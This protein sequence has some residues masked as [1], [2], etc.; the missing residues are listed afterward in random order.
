MIQLV[1]LWWAEAGR[2]GVMPLD[3]RF[4]ERS[5]P[6]VA[7]LDPHEVHLLPRCGAHP[8]ARG[9]RHAEP[10]VGGGGGGRD[11]EGRRRRA[12]RGD[13]WRHQRLV[14]LSQGGRADV[15]LQPRLDRADVHPRAEAGRARPARG[16]LRLR[17]GRQGGVRRGRHR[18]HL[19]RRQ[20]VAEGAI[21]RTAAFGYSL[22][23]TF[24]IGC[25]K[26][27]PVT[28]E[29]RALASPSP[30]RSSRSTSI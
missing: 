4:Q 8:R 26:G 28:S 12:N 6:A 20:K 17:E 15:L 22:D 7:R 5:L 23:E 10:L 18:P 21:P 25:D 9:P 11:P 24:D 19:R 14:S 29:Y 27:A 2:Y 1:G 30:A 3:N 16:A 13:G